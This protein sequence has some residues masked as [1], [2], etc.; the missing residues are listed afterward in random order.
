MSMKIISLNITEFGGLSDFSLDF[1]DGLNVIEG[2]N[3]SG[4]STVLLFVMYMLYGLPK[5]TRKGTPGEFDKDRSLSRRSGSARGSMTVECDGVKYRI[6]RKNLK[7]GKNSEVKV[8]NVDTGERVF[9]GY[10]PGVA[11]LG[12]SRETF[13]SCL[14][15]A[16]SRSFVISS[17]GVRETLSNLSLTA[18]ESVNGDK[19]K[20]T[21][22]EEKKV[23]KH[24]R[25]S[26]G[27]LNDA[28]LRVDM[29]RARVNEIDA[30]MKRTAHLRE[31]A[32]AEEAKK[33]SAE[34]RRARADAARR[35]AAS[36]ALID[37]FEELARA[38]AELSQ[39]EGQRDALA[40][41]YPISATN[42][43][44]ET[45]F[46]LRALRSALARRREDLSAST[47]ERTL[48]SRKQFLRTL[49]GTAFLR[50]PIGSTSRAL[51]L[52]LVATWLRSASRLA[53]P[54]RQRG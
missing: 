1:S 32:E 26:G 37:R 24:D 10:E 18:D 15:C 29:A 50:G 23:Y 51:H 25:G 27:L 41:C 13:E 44:R 9:E 49:I 52:H 5:S 46:K 40:E 12:V 19:V 33:R 43:D 31:E 48:Q 35:A 30:V 11:L 36:R 42:P 4:K 8:E 16:Q 45:L 7:S 54:Q 20:K 17:E 28:M 39:I 22:Q 38:K 21:L 2:A 34:E 3:E 6:E 14:W 47:I 53:K